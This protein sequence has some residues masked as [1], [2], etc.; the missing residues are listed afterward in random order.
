MSQRKLAEPT[1]ADVA[2]ML[3]KVKERM[4]ANNGGLTP[5][6]NL[7]HVLRNQSR[8]GWPVQTRGPSKAELEESARR[9]GKKAGRRAAKKAKQRA[10]TAVRTQLQKSAGYPAWTSVDPQLERIYNLQTQ[11]SKST[12]PS[13][14]MSLGAQITLERLRRAHLQGRI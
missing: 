12:D 4:L 5:T 1:T 2:F 6:G 10:K 7:Q 11:L 9:A 13:E 3:Q 14:R 8:Y